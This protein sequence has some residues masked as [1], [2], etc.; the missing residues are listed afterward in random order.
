MLKLMQAKSSSLRDPLSHLWKIAHTSPL[1][2]GIAFI[3]L[4]TSTVCARILRAQKNIDILMMM[5]YQVFQSF[6]QYLP[7]MH[8]VHWDMSL[9]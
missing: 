9:I 6:H 4:H 5:Q 8:Y 2:Q 7:S 3:A 1:R